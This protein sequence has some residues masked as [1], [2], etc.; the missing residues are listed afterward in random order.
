MTHWMTNFEDVR[1]AG[2]AGFGIG[3]SPCAPGRPARD[4]AIRTAALVDAW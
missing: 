2:A 1:L 3:A 4:V